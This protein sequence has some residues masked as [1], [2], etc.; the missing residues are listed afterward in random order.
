MDAAQTRVVVMTTTA[1]GPVTGPRAVVCSVSKS[2][3]RSYP[4]GC[5]AVLPFLSFRLPVLLDRFWM[6]LRPRRQRKH[7]VVGR[8]RQQ[9]VEDC[10]DVRL[11]VQVVPQRTG[12]QWRQHRRLLTRL[13]TPHEQSVPSTDSHLLHHLLDVVVVDRLERIIEAHPQ[14]RQVLADLLHRFSHLVLRG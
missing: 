4:S 10:F 12:R 3:G 2:S 14:W 6:R 8:A 9:G 5:A 13:D 7:V 1:Q 11:D